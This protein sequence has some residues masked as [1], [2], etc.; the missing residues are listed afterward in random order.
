MPNLTFSYLLNVNNAV[1]HRVI[2]HEGKRYSL[3]QCQV[4]EITNKRPILDVDEFPLAARCKHCIPK[5]SA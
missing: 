5:E 4:D 3:E 2:I 1:L